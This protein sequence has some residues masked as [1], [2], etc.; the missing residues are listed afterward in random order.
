MVLNVI[1]EDE[2][3]RP[4]S[5]GMIQAAIDLSEQLSKENQVA[6]TSVVPD[7][8]GGIVFTRQKGKI[9][10]KIHLWEDGNVCHS[11]FEGTTLLHRT[12]TS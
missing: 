9:V 1:L 12:Q 7:G 2:G 11:V 4:P 3:V 6:P 5:E 10:E 8:D